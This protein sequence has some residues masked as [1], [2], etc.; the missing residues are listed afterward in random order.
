MEGQAHENRVVTQLATL[1]DKNHST[2]KVVVIGAT[3]RPNSIDPSLRRPG[4]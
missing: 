4:R 3:N 2:G 1:M